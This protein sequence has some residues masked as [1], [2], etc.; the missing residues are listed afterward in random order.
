[1]S[2]P[3]KRRLHN[4]LIATR[5]DFS[6]VKLKRNVFDGKVMCVFGDGENGQS[7]EELETIVASLGG[8]V[9]KNPGMI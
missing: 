2:P 8:E 9:V 1:M 4:L 7:A 5:T 3:K 6:R